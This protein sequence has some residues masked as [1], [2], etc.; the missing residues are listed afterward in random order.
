[1]Q[2]NIPIDI[3]D[4][5]QEALNASGIA[6]CAQPLPRDLGSALPIT[7]VQPIEGGSRSSV[8]IDRMPVRLYTWDGTDEGACRESRRAFAALAAM[9][10][11]VIGGSQCYRVEASS[12]PYAAYDPDHPTLARYGFTADV[13]VRAITI[14]Y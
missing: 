13:Y 3:A 4:A 10:G 9:A 6:A 8:V 14:D 12:T 2:T 7:L 1:M 5:V 11:E